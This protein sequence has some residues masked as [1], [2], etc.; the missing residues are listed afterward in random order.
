M[1]PSQDASQ[2]QIGRF[3]GGEADSN[4]G[5]QAGLTRDIWTVINPVL[6]PLQSYINQGNRV[7]GAALA[8]TLR[9]GSKLAAAQQQ[10]ALSN[11]WTLRDQAIV[12]IANRFV[13]HPWPTT[14]LFIVDP[15]VSWIWIGAIVI[16]LG[17][18]LALW[19]GSGRPRRPRRVEEAIQAP[20]PRMRERVLEPVASVAT[21]FGRG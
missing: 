18:L 20:A 10:T 16:A 21:R 13:T 8:K 15:L 12:E 3:F 14:F 5:L 2:G 19:P 6:A 9:P 1:Y 7:F 4:V 11:L 17:G